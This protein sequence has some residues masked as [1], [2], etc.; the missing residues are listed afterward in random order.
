MALDPSKNIPTATSNDDQW[1]IWHKQLRRLFGKKQANSIW[2]FAWSKRGGL[3]T[4]ANTRKLS[5]YL[6]KFGIDVERS[7][8]D[9]IGEGFAD[10]A[11][12]FASTAKWFVIIPLGV[13][14]IVLIAILWQLIKNPDKTIGQAALLTPQGRA[15]KG[16]KGLK[17]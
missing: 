16:L 5:N 4:K 8:L 12:G 3:D 7:T 17:K 14:G 10:A 2:L 11:E 1:I 15:A 6:E 13:A 9:S